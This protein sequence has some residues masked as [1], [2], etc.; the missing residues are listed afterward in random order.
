MYLYKLGQQLFVFFMKDL[1]T[2]LL[3][4]TMC[5]T[6]LFH[7]PYWIVITQFDDNEDGYCVTDE[8]EPVGYLEMLSS[9][10]VYSFG[11]SLTTILS[12]HLCWESWFNFCL[13]F[14]IGIFLFCYFSHSVLIQLMYKQCIKYYKTLNRDT[15]KM[16]CFTV[17]SSYQVNKKKLMK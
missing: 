16:Y 17:L 10:L 14:Y 3:F 7:N 2:M 8:G 9:G 1:K 4:M 5:N 13:Q 6:E 12:L 11:S 15:S